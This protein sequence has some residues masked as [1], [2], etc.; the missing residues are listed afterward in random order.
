MLSLWALVD[1]KTHLEVPTFFKTLAFMSDIPVIIVQ[2]HIV[3]VDDLSPYVN[4]SD[5]TIK[6]AKTLKLIKTCQK[7]CCH[8]DIKAY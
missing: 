2:S 4:D 1:A 5:S 7:L 6:A 3:I 8:T